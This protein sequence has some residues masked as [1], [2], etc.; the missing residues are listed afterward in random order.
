MRYVKRP[1]AGPNATVSDPN[2][3]SL[4]LSVH[5]Q[6]EIDGIGMGVLSDGTPFLNQRGLARMCGVQNA[7]IGTISSEWLDSGKPRIAAIKKILAEKGVQMPAPHL[8]VAHGGRRM[9]AYPDVVCLAVLEYYAFDAG[10]FVQDEA[11]TRYRWLAGRSLREVIYSQLGYRPKGTIADTWRQFHD[12]VSLVYDNVP[13][14]YFCIF[15]EIAD[16]MVTLINAGAPVGDKFIPDLSVGRAWSEFWKANGLFANCGE[17]QQYIHNFPD[18]FPQA[19]SN[20]QYPWCYPEAAL[21][22]F[23]KW[24]RE[25]YLPTQLPKYLDGKVREGVLHPAAKPIIAGALKNRRPDRPAIIH[26]KTN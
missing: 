2:Q 19:A 16:V 14:G 22:S 13:E 15:K 26:R 6:D 7:H 20:P 25:I 17:R 12:R 4:E 10:Q 21:P 18:Y 11:K 5:H 9:F 1:P 8:E 3:G 24:M 23:R